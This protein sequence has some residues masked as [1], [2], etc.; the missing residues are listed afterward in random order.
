MLIDR[1][2]DNVQLQQVTLTDDLAGGHTATWTGV[3]R[4]KGRMRQLSGREVID[5]YQREAN[6][7]VHRWMT[8]DRIPQTDSER[9]L[10]R[11]LRKSGEERFRI[12]W[13]G[14]R[15][16]T[17]IGVNRPSGGNVNAA[18][19]AVYID[20]IETPEGRGYQDL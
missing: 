8:V 2:N 17:I 20:C 19:D 11:L 9:S 13:E 12:L 10:H 1:H 4:L 14:D 5:T 18:A 16:M 7:D 6:E 3:M 15:S